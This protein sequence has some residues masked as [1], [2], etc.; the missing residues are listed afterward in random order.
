LHFFEKF[1]YIRILNYHL[2]VL[3]VRSGRV[4]SIRNCWIG[5]RGCQTEY[6]LWSNSTIK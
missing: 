2:H 5:R 4:W 3:L 1:G 6:M